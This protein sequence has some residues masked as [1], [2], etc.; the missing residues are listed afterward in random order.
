LQDH[1]VFQY[2]VKLW[3]KAIFTKRYNADHCVVG[4]PVQ[5][6]GFPSSL[7]D[8][9]G[10]LFQTRQCYTYKCVDSTKGSP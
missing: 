10:E 1:L 2:H 8:L 5:K 4:P 6:T 7:V 3:W 9:L